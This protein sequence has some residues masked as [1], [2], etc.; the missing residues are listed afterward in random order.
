MTQRKFLLIEH[1]SAEYEQSL[2]L[3]DEV[4]RKP[5]GLRFSDEDLVLERDFYHL[6]C[7]EDGRVVGCLVLVPQDEEDVRMRQVVVV[8]HLQ[9]QGI[10][11]G[12]IEFAEAVA[13]EEGFTI[14]T[15]NARD[16]A[17]VF[18]EKLDYQQVGE[19]F[20]EVTIR[21]WK[22]RKGL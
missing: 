13:R 8:P 21:H 7:L 15:L 4:L 16:S 11:R 2:V 10:G 9:R 12:L 20:V 3:R 1:G 17:K 22:M 14:I 19:P 5:L 6:V 18:Y